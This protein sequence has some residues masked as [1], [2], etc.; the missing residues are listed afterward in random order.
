MLQ[1][2][3]HNSVANW[4]K[5]IS[6]L[7]VFLPLLLASC[8]K[9]DYPTVTYPPAGGPRFSNPQLE[10]TVP[11][12]SLLSPS[13]LKLPDIQV[14]RPSAE[15]IVRGTLADEISDDALSESTIGIMFLDSSENP[16]CVALCLP[17]RQSDGSLGFEAHIL[18][19]A[20]A[21]PYE[22]VV[23]RLTDP[24]EANRTLV[25]ARAVVASPH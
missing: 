20:R 10:I 16:A 7:A 1:C 19:P 13:M 18:G 11:A 22:F 25:S 4:M 3:C 15:L 14:P 12:I 23:R 6:K 5:C 8:N 2:R 21:G 17:E 9:S 24:A